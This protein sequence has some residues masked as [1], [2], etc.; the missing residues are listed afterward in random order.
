MVT[1]RERFERVYAL[2]EAVAPADL[3]RESDRRRGRRLPA[4]EDGRVRAGLTQLNGVSQ[5]LMRTVPAAE[6]AAW[7]A[8]RWPT[9]R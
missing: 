9:G 1:R 5:A 4:D 3:I 2:T 8:R 6:I 7:R